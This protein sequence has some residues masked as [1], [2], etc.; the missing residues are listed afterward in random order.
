[1]AEEYIAASSTALAL[2]PREARGIPW[3]ASAMQCDQT[4]GRILD[5]AVW[6]VGYLPSRTA[7]IGNTGLSGAE[8]MRPDF[9]TAMYSIP[10]QANVCISWSSM[11]L[12]SFRRR[13][14]G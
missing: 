3:A 7:V 12:L 6:D 11:T 13:K 4:M 8:V 5:Q 14:L 1:M 2:L 9:R 10:T